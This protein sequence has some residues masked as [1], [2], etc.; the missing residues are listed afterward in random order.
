MD[1]SAVVCPPALAGPVVIHPFRALHLAADRVG[2][3]A[4]A[5]AFAHPHDRV[6]GRLAGWLRQGLAVEEETPAVWVHEYTARGMT[7]RGIVGAL[8][9]TRPAVPGTSPGVLP[10]ERVLPAQVDELERRMEEMQLQPAAILLAHRASPQL[11][12][13]VDR[14]VAGP[15]DLELDDPTGQQHRAWAVTDAATVDELGVRLA[16]TQALIADGHHRYAAYL[17]LCAEHGADG[18]WGRGLAMLVDHDDTPLFLGAIHRLLRGARVTRLVERARAVGLE[19]RTGSRPQALEALD[20][21]VLVVADQRDAA[22]IRVPADRLPVELLHHDLVPALAEAGLPRPSIDHLHTAEQAL[23][24]AD[25]GAGTAVLLPAL[26]LDEVMRVLRA[27][28]LLPEKA[29][30]FQPKPSVGVLMRPVHDGVD[31]RT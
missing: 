23:S 3:A 29:T 11:R 27:G 10:H 21:Q 15:P 12:A 22:W 4:G 28:R 17:R 8:D 7:V 30:S 20:R 1:E 16:G 24:R 5:R 18:P 2:T 19:V 25:A 31:D 6:P 14:V 26:E 9:L 13:L